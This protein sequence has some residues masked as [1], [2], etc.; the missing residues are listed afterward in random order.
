MSEKPIEQRARQAA[1]IYRFGDSSP[2]LGYR[3]LHLW[4]GL[5]R[6]AKNTTGASMLN[7]RMFISSS[8]FHLATAVA[9]RP[10]L[11]PGT[12]V[13]SRASSTILL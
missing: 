5:S 6:L 1:S 4:V 8:R 2:N 10:P 3:N 9:T 12:A 13:C 11:A 7:P